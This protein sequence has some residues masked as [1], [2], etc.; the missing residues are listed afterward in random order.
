MASH[1]TPSDRQD[2]EPW[3]DW[4]KR[5]PQ[6]VMIKTIWT[7]SQPYL[8]NQSG[9]YHA[10]ILAHVLR[11]NR[12]DAFK[13]A[14]AAFNYALTPPKYWWTVIPDFIDYVKAGF[15]KEDWEKALVQSSQ[16]EFVN[17]EGFAMMLNRSRL[18]QG[19]KRDYEALASKSRGHRQNRNRT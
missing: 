6:V 4:A 9:F 16:S 12:P 1:V 17:Q 11:I 5:A 13:N 14:M 3:Q 15:S 19:W 7:G 8:K 18:T 2:F 10:A